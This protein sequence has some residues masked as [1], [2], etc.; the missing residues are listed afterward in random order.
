MAI[1]EQSREYCKNYFEN[2]SQ[3]G[4]K[5]STAEQAEE[6]VKD[7][8]KEKQHIKLVKRSNRELGFDFRDESSELFVEVKGS[9]KSFK[10]FPGCYFTNSEYEKARSC[11]KEKK[12]YQIHLIVGI[13]SES[14]EHHIEPGKSLLDKAKAEVWWCLTGKDFRA[15]NLKK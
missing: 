10:R 3:R 12:K 7:Y 4:K 5:M 13:G 15:A 9:E 8:F 6:Y 11:R 1:A 14:P 2:L